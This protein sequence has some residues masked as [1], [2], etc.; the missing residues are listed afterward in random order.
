M[1]IAD[2]MNS[3]K[4]VNDTLSSD[5]RGYKYSAKNAASTNGAVMLTWLVSTAA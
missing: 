2:P 5:N 4:L 1:L 3:A